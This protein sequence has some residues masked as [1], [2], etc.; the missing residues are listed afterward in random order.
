M[1]MEQYWT[2]L[3]HFALLFLHIIDIRLKFLSGYD[4]VWDWYEFRPNRPSGRFFLKILFFLDISL[5]LKE[6]FENF[7]FSTTPTDYTRNI[8]NAEDGEVNALVLEKEIFPVH[9]YCIHIS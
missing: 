4:F 3:Q 6:K 9:Y 1:G 2:K 7:I 8:S 5:S